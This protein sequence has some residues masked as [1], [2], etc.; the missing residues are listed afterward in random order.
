[1]YWN[2][3]SSNTCELMM[4]VTA[5]VVSARANRYQSMANGPSVAELYGS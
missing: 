2:A 5:D 4:Y 1:M 3:V